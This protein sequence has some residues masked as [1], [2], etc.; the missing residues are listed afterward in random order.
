MENKE[1][2][3][4][5][6]WCV[7]VAH[8]DAYQPPECQRHCISGVVAE[9]TSSRSGVTRTNVRVTTS[10]IVSVDGKE[11]TTRSGSVYT[12]GKVEESYREWLKENRP[13][14]DEENPITMI[15]E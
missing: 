4:I 14:W 1:K 5:E 11:V 6:D 9:H 10:Y 2:R 13:D 3:M 8:A 7:S 15:G 12:L